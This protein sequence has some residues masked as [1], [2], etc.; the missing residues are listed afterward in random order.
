MLC[1][2]SDENLLA[3]STVSHF[4]DW[5]CIWNFKESISF[6]ISIYEAHHYSRNF[7][8]RWAEYH[9]S[10]VKVI[11]SAFSQLWPSN[12]TFA[13]LRTESVK[14][15]KKSE[16]K[17]K[18]IRGIFEKLQITTSVRILRISASNLTQR[19]FRMFDWRISGLV[20]KNW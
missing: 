16:R 6:L 4:S 17:V 10:P 15:C 14:E 19:L 20:L 7:V 1:Q 9:A 13:P 5:S 8:L 12:N 3:G 18:E 2:V 11:F